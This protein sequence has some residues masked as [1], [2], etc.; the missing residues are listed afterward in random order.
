MQSDNNGS[1]SGFYDGP[2]SLL[3]IRR[4]FEFVLAP[5]PMKPQDRDAPL[6][7]YVGIDLAI[8]ILIRDHLAASAEADK[9]SIRRPASLFQA[10]AVAF[11]FVA[12]VLKLADPRHIAATAKLDV[13]PAQE[14]VFL[15]ETPPRHVQVHAPHAVVIVNRHF[16]ELRK[17]SHQI[18]S[19]RISQVPSNRSR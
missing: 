14:F 1:T 11:V 7:L 9:R 18:A 2:K 16:F 6:V 10:R 3:H 4:H 15:S 19:Y 12:D 17:M 13:I 5:L 8:T